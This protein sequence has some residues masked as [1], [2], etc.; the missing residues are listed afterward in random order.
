MIVIC[1]MLEDEIF[2]TMRAFKS[3]KSRKGSSNHDHVLNNLICMGLIDWDKEEV[4]PSIQQFL[5]Y[6]AIMANRLTKTHNDLVH[7]V[8]G[9]D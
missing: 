7:Q 6:L 9:L 2:L 3:Y 4:M 5:H 8:G 1:K